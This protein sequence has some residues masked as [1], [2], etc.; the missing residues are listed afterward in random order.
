LQVQLSAK[1]KERVSELT[2]FEISTII[3][4]G[5]VALMNMKPLR[6]SD[7]ID[8]EWD[9]PCDYFTNVQYPLEVLD[10]FSLSSL[11]IGNPDKVKNIIKLYE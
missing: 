8:L 11:M 7:L 2:D 6:L 4:R 3:H 9:K 1:V 10:G 5:T